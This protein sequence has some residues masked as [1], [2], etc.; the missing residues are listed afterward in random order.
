ME[1]QL[2]NGLLAIAAVSADAGLLVVNRF[3]LSCKPSCPLP[4]LHLLNIWGH[5]SRH[6]QVSFHFRTSTLPKPS[7]IDSTHSRFPFPVTTT[8][9][10][11]LISFLLIIIA[12][13]LTSLLLW[14]LTPRESVVSL[15]ADQESLLREDEKLHPHRTEALRRRSPLRRTAVHQRLRHVFWRIIPVAIVYVAKIVLANV[16]LTY[17]CF[18]IKED[19]D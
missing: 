12:E 15:D 19:I 1:R 14:C 4:S 5:I 3:A 8:L 6:I 10:Q 11:S 2:L 18:R 17:V 13:R 16:F 7:S 9:I